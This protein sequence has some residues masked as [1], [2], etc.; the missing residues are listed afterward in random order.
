MGKGE[1]EGAM[2]PV[3]AELVSEVVG[4]S[5]TSRDGRLER[6]VGWGDGSAMVVGWYGT[7]FDGD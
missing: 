2:T 4:P 3:G 1:E 7:V 5:W 6:G